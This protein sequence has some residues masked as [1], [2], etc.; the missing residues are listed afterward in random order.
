M[1]LTGDELLSGDIADTNSDFMAKELADIG[2]EVQKKLIVGDN[3]SL[4]VEALTYLS[5]DNDVVIVNGGLGATEDDL[6][7]EASAMF[8]GDSLKI[9]PDVFQSV[10]QK[11][12]LGVLVDNPEFIQ[13]IEKQSTLPESAEVIENGVGIAFG[14]KVKQK[15]TVF[16]F[17][18]GVPREMRKMLTDYILP[19]IQ[20]TYF[21]QEKKITAKIHVIG[22]IGESRIQQIIKDFIPADIW[23]VVKLG[24]RAGMASVEIKLSVKSEKD[25]AVLEE[26]EKNIRGYFSESLLLASKSLPRMIIDI[27]QKRGGKLALAESCTGGLVASQITSISGASAVFEAG[28]VTYANESKVNQLKI[29][30]QFIETYG[31]VSQEVAVKMVEGL[32]LVTQADFGVAITGIA[33]PTGGTEEKPVGTVF[34]AWGDRD[35]I[36]TRKFLIKRERTEFQRYVAIVALDA[37]RKYLLNFTSE[38][39][40]YFDEIS[41][42]RFQAIDKKGILT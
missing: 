26:V 25:L 20:K 8:C 1:L 18:P 16:Y 19:D 14:Y 22:G 17:T 42:H 35:R 37:L 41:K 13:Q 24:F 15:N 31:A 29:P 23:K 11:Y 36:E 5:S 2:I 33:G 34:V 7:A 40:Y 38:T 32:F 4:L 27:L 9:H 12:G 6:S 39:S 30:E 21:S 3:L 28:L 10:K